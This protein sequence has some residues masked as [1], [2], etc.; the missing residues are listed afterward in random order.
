[1]AF[2]FPGVVRGVGGG[3]VDGQQ[4]AVEDD[5]R[6]LP[7]RL[8]RVG[9]GRGEGGQ[10]VDGLAYVAEGG[11][12]PDA[13]TGRERGVGA[14]AP[15]VGQ[16]QQGLS[17]CG[18]P[19]PPRAG[20]LPPGGQVPGQEPQGAGGQIDR[21]RADK[22]PKLLADT[23]D[24]GREPVCQELRRCAGLSNSPPAPPAWKTLTVREIRGG[25]PSPAA[26]SRATLT[27]N[28]CSA[29]PQCQRSGTRTPAG[30]SSAGASPPG[31]APAHP[32]RRHVQARHRQL[33]R[34]PRPHD[35][36]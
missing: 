36:P 35:L 12:D 31:E 5:E 22:Q 2:V 4:G 9:Q 1:M 28:A 27:S 14:T 25:S 33:A 29:A 19:P 17:C 26:P 16:G 20:L 18:K 13:E 21:R 6:L 8:H 10:D 32:G 23:G 11:R 30:P 24:L 15:Q 7:D 34:A 3:A